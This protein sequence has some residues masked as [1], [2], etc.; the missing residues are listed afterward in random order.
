MQLTVLTVLNSKC[1]LDTGHVVEGKTDKNCPPGRPFIILLD[2]WKQNKTK[3]IIFIDYL[4]F[5]CF[6]NEFLFLTSFFKGSRNLIYGTL[7]LNFD[8]N[9]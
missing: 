1:W 4:L 9:A 7:S 8:L 5:S 6:F 3:K 2:L